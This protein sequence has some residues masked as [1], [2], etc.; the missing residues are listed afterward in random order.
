[1]KHNI[2]LHTIQIF[3]EIISSGVGPEKLHNFIAALKWN[4]NL[5][6]LNK[7]KGWEKELFYFFLAESRE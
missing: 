5:K 6:K 4:V 2:T 3:I 7:Q 1:M